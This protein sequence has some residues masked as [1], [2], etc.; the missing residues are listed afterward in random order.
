MKDVIKETQNVLS[1]GGNVIKTR[2]EEGLRTTSMS[3]N[4]P[5]SEFH[6]DSQICHQDSR[7]CHQDSRI[8]KS[9]S[10]ATCH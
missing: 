3:A 2:D 8:R 10:R 1:N 5:D 6:Q 7:I 9:L 4:Q